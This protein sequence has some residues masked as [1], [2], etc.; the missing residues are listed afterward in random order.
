[1]DKVTP[2]LKAYSALIGAVCTALLGI[3]GPDTEVGHWLTIVV[4]VLSA[5]ATYAVPNKD[6]RARHQAESVQPPA[7]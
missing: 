6:P 1:M 7:A 4:A 3:Y 2:Y 5:V